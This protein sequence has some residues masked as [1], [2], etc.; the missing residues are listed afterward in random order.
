MSRMLAP[1]YHLN[2]FHFMGKPDM[3]VLENYEKEGGF[4]ALKKVLGQSEWT[5]EK[6]IDEV[7]ASGLGG[8]GGAGFPTGM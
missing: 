2:V 4:K 1:L 7:K 3:D 6:V 8:R 5:P